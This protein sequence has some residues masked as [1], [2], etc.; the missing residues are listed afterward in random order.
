[1][2]QSSDERICVGRH[3]VMPGKPAVVTSAAHPCSRSCLA[4]RL[5]T[6]WIE[7]NHITHL[8]APVKALPICA[9]DRCEFG[10]TKVSSLVPLAFSVVHH[11]G[12]RAFAGGYENVETLNVSLL[13]QRL[14]QDT[15]RNY[16]SV[17]RQKSDDLTLNEEPPS[18]SDSKDD[19]IFVVKMRHEPHVAAPMG[20]HLDNAIQ[21]RASIG[22]PGFDRL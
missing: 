11:R 22:P 8:G 5:R 9:D 14:V 12:H 21:L 10:A 20:H 4:H 3:A 1:V 19:L 18:A 6:C 15:S 7:C 13:R 17:A 16:N 2:I